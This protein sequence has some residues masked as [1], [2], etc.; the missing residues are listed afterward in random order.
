M[1]FSLTS[2]RFYGIDSGGPSLKRGHQV[3]ELKI[4]GTA[5]DVDLDIGDD[6]GTF[7]TAA[8]AAATGA[9]A[10]NVLTLL[11][12]IEGKGALGCG[13]GSKELRDRI[14]IAA[15]S[16]A[17]EYSLAWEGQRPNIAFNAAD[18]ETSLIVVLTYLLADGQAYVT[19][20]FGPIS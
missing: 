19:Q 11:Q 12:D 6:D 2:A 5:A 3:V 15:V 20:N 9:M 17:G 16:G 13:V 4:A 1:S 14:Q 7:W 18:G 10:T 8:I